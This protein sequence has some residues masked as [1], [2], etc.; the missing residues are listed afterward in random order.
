MNAKLM[1]A[2]SVMFL[3]GVFSVA[4]SSI[5]IECYNKNEQTKKEKRTN[6]DF[7]VFNL[8]SAIIVII[9]ASICIYMGL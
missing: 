1:I 7:L 9:V 3:G 4:T 8:I 6:F 2:A 5:A